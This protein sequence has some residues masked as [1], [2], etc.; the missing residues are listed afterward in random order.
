MSF[1]I[2]QLVRHTACR[3]KAGCQDINEVFE[4]VEYTESESGHIYCRKY[5]DGTTGSFHDWELTAL[6]EEEALSVVV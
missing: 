4:V 6:T 1:K 3:N 2:G 5:T